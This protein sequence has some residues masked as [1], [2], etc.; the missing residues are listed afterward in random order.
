MMLNL[1]IWP[2]SGQDA[3]DLKDEGMNILSGL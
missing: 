3:S 1:A 2:Q